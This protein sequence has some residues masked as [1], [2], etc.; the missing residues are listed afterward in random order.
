MSRQCNSKTWWIRTTATLL[1]VSFE[2]YGRHRRDV[3]MGRRG[4]V[5]LRRLGDMPLKN[6]WVFHLR[7]AWNVV[8][9][10][11]SDV[12]VTSST[13]LRR[14]HDVPIKPYGNVLLRRLGDVLPRRHWVFHLRRTCDV[15]G[16]YRETLLQP[17]HGVLVLGGLLKMLL[18]LII[19]ILW[20]VLN[21]EALGFVSAFQA[22]LS[23]HH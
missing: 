3:L 12:V 16:T 15:A 18:Y 20:P 6:H 7:L 13:S 4:Y 9:I 8:E 2:S 22:K 19:L 14:R 11:W 1:G 10:Y 21:L 23:N 17:L 5:P